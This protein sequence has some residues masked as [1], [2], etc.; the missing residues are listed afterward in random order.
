MQ[1]QHTGVVRVYF[2]EKGFGFIDGD[3][4][5]ARFFHASKVVG[6][7]IPRVG[8]RVAYNLAP[9]DKKPGEVQAIDIEI[10]ASAVA[11]DGSAQ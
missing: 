9:S 1:T 10:V 7:R 3:D 2:R 5:Y 11:S 4:Q 8:E 6:Y